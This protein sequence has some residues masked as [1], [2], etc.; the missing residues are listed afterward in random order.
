MNPEGGGC[1]EPRSCH[2][3]TSWA[4]GQDSV[5]KMK[6]Q[7]TKTVAYGKVIIRG[8]VMAIN[9]YI[10]DKRKISNKQPNLNLKKLEKEQTKPKFSGR[11]E[12]TKIEA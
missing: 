12:I 5:K 11:K 10:K 2:C 9:V 7:Y 8:K 6:T 3:T 1:S 4:T